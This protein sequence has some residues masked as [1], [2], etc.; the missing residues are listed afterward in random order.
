MK[1]TFVLS[2]LVVMALSSIHAAYAADE[3]F[4][5]RTGKTLHYEITSKFNTTQR[6]FIEPFIRVR[7]AWKNSAVG[8]GKD[9]LPGH[10]GWG[11][12]DRAGTESHDL[13]VIGMNDKVTLSTWVD[14]RGGNPTT[15]LFV[16]PFSN[17]RNEDKVYFMKARLA[18]NTVIIDGSNQTFTPTTPI[19]PTPTP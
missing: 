16:Y 12:R 6:S 11:G 5:C 17:W 8:F 7:F 18:G 10:C 15:Q 19:G 13:Q 2:T 4:V 3:W 1:K 9:L 14:G